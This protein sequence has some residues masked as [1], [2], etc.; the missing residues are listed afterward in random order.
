[1]AR[2]AEIPPASQ[3]LELVTTPKLDQ[4]AENRAMGEQPAQ[5]R[6]ARLALDYDR[7]LD[8]LYGQRQ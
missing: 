2:R 8:P 3:G 6:A 4:R 1:M 7:A 5:L